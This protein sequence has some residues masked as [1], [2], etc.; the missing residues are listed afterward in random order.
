[1]GKVQDTKRQ[2]KQR[3]ANIWEK[4]R[5]STDVESTGYQQMGKST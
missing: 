2:E 1:M 5:I 3:I 4:Q